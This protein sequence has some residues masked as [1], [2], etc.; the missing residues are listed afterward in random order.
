MVEGDGASAEKDEGKRK[1]GESHPEAVSVI[2]DQPVVRGYLPDS[3]AHIDANSESRYAREQAQQHKQSAKELGEG[4]EIR[5]PGGQTKATDQLNVVVQSAENLVIAKVDHDRAESQAHDEKSERLQTI[6]KTQT[7]SSGE[8]QHRLQ[9]SRDGGKASA[10]L[11]GCP[12]A[13]ALDP[14]SERS[15]ATPEK[16][17]RS[18]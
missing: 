8:R 15:F 10:G 6:Q 18:G 13:Y 11:V 7:S 4:R 17:L 14:L 3:D 9:E 1:S 16:R 5:A 2:R 12:L